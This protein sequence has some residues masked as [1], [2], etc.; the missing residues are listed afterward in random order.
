MPTRKPTHNQQKT[1]IAYNIQR[2]HAQVC[3]AGSGP[4]GPVTTQTIV[5]YPSWKSNSLDLNLYSCHCCSCFR[6]CCCCQLLLCL[7]MLLLLLL[8]LLVMVVLLLCCCRRRRR[9]RRFCWCLVIHENY[10]ILARCSGCEGGGVAQWAVSP[11]GFGAAV[12][13]IFCHVNNNDNGTKW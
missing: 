2:M 4:T 8:L 1:N 10:L 12:I 3:I 5:A 6:C 13:A 9:R 7:L 11:L